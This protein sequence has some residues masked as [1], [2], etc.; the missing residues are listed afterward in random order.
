MSLHINKFV[1]QLAAQESR[2][3]QDFVI[4]M[5]DA[6]NLLLDITRLLSRLEENSHKKS[7]ESTITVDL[8]GG[9][10]R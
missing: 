2:G 6:K 3:R 1:D 8:T 5:K 10:F 9:N 4:P 7:P